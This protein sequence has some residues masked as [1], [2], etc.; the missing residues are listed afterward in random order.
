MGSRFA[1]NRFYDCLLLAFCTYGSGDY[2]GRPGVGDRF[3]VE[4]QGGK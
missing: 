2:C 1:V 3:P 4:W